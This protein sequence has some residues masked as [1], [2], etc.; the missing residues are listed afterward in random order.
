MRKGNKHFMD[1]CLTYK[2]YLLMNKLLS[3]IIPTYNK[4]NTLSK[5]LSSVLNHKW[6]DCLEVVVVNDGSK[7]SSLKIANQ[8]RNDYPKVV[9]VLDK[10]NGNYGSTINAA[11][12]IIE[13]KYVKILDA[14]DWFDETEFRYFIE[15]LKTVEA[16]L[17]IT[18]FMY[19]HVSGKMT[20]QSYYEWEYGK[21]YQ[22]DEIAQSKTILNNLFMHAVTYR[23][24]ILKKNNY[25][26]TEG[27]SYTDNEWIFYPMFHVQSVVFLN[28]LV[29]HYSVGVDGQTMSPDIY[30]RNAPKTQEFAKRMLLAYAHYLKGNYEPNRREYLLARLKWLIFP[31]YKI[32]LVL[33][34]KDEFDSKKVDDLERA[35]R[36]ADI[37]LYNVMGHF[38]VGH[39]FHYHYLMYWRRFRLRMPRFFV[40]YLITKGTI[41]FPLQK[42]ER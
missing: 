24:E 1:I 41:G 35:I 20:V 14:D 26:Q 29:Y 9:K 11:L 15:H 37:K 34:S 18:H 23:T 17:V 7:D 2:I 32:Y 13:G 21:V 25:R 6:D 10:T 30:I 5:C 31:I 40:R 38:S 33:Q 8:Y 27:V 28:Y 39:M 22:F 3:I 42:K 4:E 12:P 36:N 19:N 16:D